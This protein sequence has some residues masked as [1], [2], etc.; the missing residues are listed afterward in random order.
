MI[1]ISR[2][3]FG[4]VICYYVEWPGKIRKAATGITEVKYFIHLN[5]NGKRHPQIL[6]PSLHSKVRKFHIFTWTKYY[7]LTKSIKIPFKKV[8]IC[9]EDKFTK[10]HV[11]WL[12]P[13]FISSIRLR[14]RFRVSESSMNSVFCHQSVVSKE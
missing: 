3:Y 7:S 1:K 13:I 5:G 2:I 8:Y 11:Y 14:T 9:V 10:L 6:L 12:D 4:L